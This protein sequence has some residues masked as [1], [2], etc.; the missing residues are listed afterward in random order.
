[1]LYLHSDKSKL[2]INRVESLVLCIGLV[3]EISY[4]S[5]FALYINEDNNY[6][7]YRGRTQLYDILF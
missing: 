4:Y 3:S 5:F 1:M 7:S 2:S 6:Y